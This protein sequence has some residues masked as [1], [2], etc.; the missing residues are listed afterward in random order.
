MRPSYLA[1]ATSSFWENGGGRCRTGR[2][3]GFKGGNKLEGAIRWS[4]PGART[5]EALGS[6]GV[7][8]RQLEHG[9]GGTLSF[10]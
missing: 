5:G 3:H 2:G 6:V 9:H 4:R 8:A 7:R 10:A 1:A